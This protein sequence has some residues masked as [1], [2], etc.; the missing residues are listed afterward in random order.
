MAE[1]EDKVCIFITIVFLKTYTASYTLEHSEDFQDHI[2]CNL[3]KHNYTRLSLETRQT[4][5]LP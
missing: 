2:A 5:D 4:V 1:L 3:N